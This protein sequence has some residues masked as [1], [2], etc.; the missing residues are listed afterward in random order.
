MTGASYVLLAAVAVS[1]IFPRE[2]AALAMCFLAFGDPVAGISGRYLRAGKV[3]Y[4]RALAADALCLGTC[5]VLGLVLR[6]MGLSVDIM[7][8]VAGSLG[9]T[10]GQAVPLRLN[11]NLLMPLLAGAAICLFRL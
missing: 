9:A 3:C 7:D 8:I 10:L 4:P 2:V 1:A 5:L 11:D 6:W